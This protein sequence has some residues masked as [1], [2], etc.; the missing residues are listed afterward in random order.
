MQQAHSAS[1]IQDGLP[2]DFPHLRLPFPNQRPPPGART[3][4]KP[5]AVG[6][7]HRPCLKR[8]VWA[9]PAAAARE[10]RGAV[11]TARRRTRART[12]AQDKTA[13]ACDALHWRSPSTFRVAGSLLFR[14]PGALATRGPAAVGAARDR[15]APFE[16][17]LPLS[18]RLCV[19]DA[20]SAL[21]YGAGRSQEP[22]RAQPLRARPACVYPV[23][24]SNG[25]T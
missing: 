3:R 22:L 9:G 21:P 13:R 11:A 12:L 24:S 14:R 5:L 15:R 23:C 25:P 6:A 1:D 19:W 20:R 2:E 4:L 10:Q 17:E 8:F 16:G 18:V 7:H